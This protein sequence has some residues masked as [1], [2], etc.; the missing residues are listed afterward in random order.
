MTS[1]T[2]PQLVAAAEAAR[3]LGVSRRRVLKLAAST[4]DFPPAEHTSTGGRAW[5]RRAV[6]AWAATAVRKRPVPPVNAISLRAGPAM[7][8]NWPVRLPSGNRMT[9]LQLAA[10]SWLVM[11]ALQQPGALTP[12]DQQDGR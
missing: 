1:R 5:P 12:P 2:D 9:R 8:T 4:A 6:Q 11:G 7:A 3:L 10:S